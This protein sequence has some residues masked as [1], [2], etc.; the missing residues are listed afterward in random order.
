MEAF[1]MKITNRVVKSRY[2]HITHCL[3]NREA[4]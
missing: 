4:I 1:E 2:A 3:L